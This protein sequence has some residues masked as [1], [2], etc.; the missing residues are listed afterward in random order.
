[1]GIDVRPNCLR[2]LEMHGNGVS[3]KRV[4]EQESLM[5]AKER[6]AWLKERN[7]SSREQWKA[8]EATVVWVERDESGTS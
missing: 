6:G 3:M 4:V 7:E 1:M 8:V 5:G 2:A